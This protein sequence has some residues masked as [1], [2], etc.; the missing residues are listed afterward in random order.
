MGVVWKL[1]DSPEQLKYVFNLDHNL[2]ALS[3]GWTDYLFDALT[4]EGARMILLIM[5]F[6]GV[7][8]ELH[9]PGVGVGGFV[10]VVGGNFVFLVAAFTGQSCSA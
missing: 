7:Y 10:A 4:S 2:G 5:L 1:I 9:S 6:V 8:L 3:P